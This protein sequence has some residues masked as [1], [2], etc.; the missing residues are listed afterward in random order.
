MSRIA[1]VCPHC[2]REGKLPESVKSL[3][4]S[5]KCPGCRNTFHPAPSQPDDFEAVPDGTAPLGDWAKRTAAGVGG[6]MKDAAKKAKDYATSDDAK[7]AMEAAWLKAGEV[8]SRAKGAASAVRGGG[9]RILEKP[10]VVALSMVF[11]FPVGLLLVWRHSLWS[12]PVKWAWTGAFLA[13]LVLMSIMS[14]QARKAD[15]EALAEADARWQA[16]DKASAVAKYRPILTRLL[17]DEKPLAY[18]RVVDYEMERGDAGAARKL[19]GEAH[20]RGVYPSVNNPEAKA[21]LVRIAAEAAEAKALLAKREQAAKSPSGGPLKSGTY[22][23][24]DS[25]GRARRLEIGPE[26]QESNAG[27]ILITP[28]LN[29]ITNWTLRLAKKPHV[30]LTG[31]DNRD[32]ILVS[33]TFD[34]QKRIR[35]GENMSLSFGDKILPGTYAATDKFAI[36]NFPIDWDGLGSLAS[37]HGVVKIQV[38][39]EEIPFLNSNDELNSFVNRFHYLL[40]NKIIPEDGSVVKP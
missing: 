21:I 39:E 27:E 28:A 22:V 31:G 4:K 33:V 1:V 6:A 40:R 7:A 17:D 36:L 2:G 19:L 26:T 30:S 3:P 15:K 10:I 18:G 9:A 25:N 14:A 32:E 12:K 20:G 38:N 8:G 13:F 11:C 24:I 16:G 23:R 29:G 34:I 35:N 37:Y 5:V